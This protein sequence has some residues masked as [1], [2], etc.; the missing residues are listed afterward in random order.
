MSLHALF[1][2]V[3]LV[4]FTADLLPHSPLLHPAE[5]VVNTPPGR[6]VAWQHPPLASGLVQIQDRVDHVPPLVF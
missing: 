4:E 6:E 1:F 2:S 3:K 5:V